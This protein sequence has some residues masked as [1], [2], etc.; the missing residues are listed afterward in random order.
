[1]ISS[2]KGFSLV[3]MA[4]VLLIVGLLLGSMLVPLASQ[5]DARN[6]SETQRRLDSASEAILGFAIAN[7]R[8][9][10]P[11]VSGATGI[12]APA[13]GGTCTTNFNGFLP[14]KTIGFQPTD[15]NGY[16]I[17][18]WGNPIRYAVASA[19][20]AATGGTCTGTLPHFTSQANMKA[21][22]LSCVPNDLDVICSTASAGAGLAAT[23]NSSVH[24]ASQKTV[25]YVVFSVGK[26][27]ATSG[28]ADETENT[29]GNSTFVLRTASESGSTLGQFD[30]M[31]V[32]VPVGVLYGKLVAAGALP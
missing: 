10:C 1:M 18:A 31:M 28:G 2:N 26:N 8:L 29:N 19:V 21:N 27:G 14:A 23:C 20:T 9:P 30:D 13:G 6:F 25:A 24:V 15:A 22:G 11:A 17:D 3:E 5:S 7:R 32:L 16:A 12:E 4:I